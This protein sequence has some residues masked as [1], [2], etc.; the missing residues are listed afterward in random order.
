[1]FKRSGA[2]LHM[3]FLAALLA[4][5]PVLAR[6]G[7][8]LKRV[9]ALGVGLADPGTG[10]KL[11]STT[12]DAAMVAEAFEQ[13]SGYDP[14]ASRIVKLVDDDPDSPARPT[15]DEI[16]R[17]LAA[18]AGEAGEGDRVVFY[19]S[20]HGDKD[21]DGR[22]F[23]VCH[24]GRDKEDPRSRLPLSDVRSILAE[25]GA[26]SKLVIV[27]ACHSGGKAGGANGLTPEEISRA[28]A[29]ES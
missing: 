26:E 13:A 23:L 8:D 16:R 19:F 17:R 1:M 12:R 24:G 28:F 4:A 9:H 7:E 21:G 15:P 22:S 14:E 18:M 3:A 10:H 2:M 20:G 27:D 5:A 6:A 25:S 11:D 29:P